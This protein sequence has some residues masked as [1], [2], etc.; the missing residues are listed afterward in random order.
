VIVGYDR[1]SQELLKRTG[2]LPMKLP[3]NFGLSKPNDEYYY[4]PSS[5]TAAASTTT[6]TAATAASADLGML[7]NTAVGGGT[8]YMHIHTYIHT[9]I[10]PFFA[11]P[12]NDNDDSAEHIESDLLYDILTA[13]PLTQGAPAARAGKVHECHM[14][15]DGFWSM[16]IAY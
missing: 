9:Y 6:S 14:M 4:K 2:R 16:S 7:A 8:W 11:R 12:C 1:G 15:P 10:F 13:D 5:A 3:W